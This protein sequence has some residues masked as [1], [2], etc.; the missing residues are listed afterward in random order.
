MIEMNT[1]IKAFRLRTLPL[2]FSSILMAAFLAYYSGH[3]Q[4]LILVLSLFTTLFLQVLSN[5]AND[6]GDALSGVDGPDRRGP[7]RS[8]QSGAITREQMKIAIILYACLSFISG[9]ILIVY[10]F[11]DHW[12]NLLLFLTL[13]LG[14]IAAAIKYTMG[15]NPYGYSGFGDVFVFIFFGLIGVFGGYYL[16]NRELEIIFLLPAVSCGLLSVGVLNVNNIRDIS[17]D[18]KAGKRS[19]PVMIGKEKA[20]IYHGFLIVGSFISAIFF[21][22]I[23]M[24]SFFGYTF[25]ALIP[26]FFFHFKA[27]QTKENSSLDAELKRLAFATLF[28]VLLLGFGIN[29]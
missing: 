22:S 9:G 3:F 10:V 8:V 28:F 19:I 2:A 14:A 7:Q 4:V 11:K 23:L 6:Y 15:S 27:V 26:V 25:L 17:S 12:L 5:L 13:G 29:Y 18:R 20:I 21:V 24:P 1:W 16:F